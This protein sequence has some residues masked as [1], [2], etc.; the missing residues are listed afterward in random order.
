MQWWHWKRAEHAL[1]A[2]VRALIGAR[3]Y[4]IRF[5][6]GKGSFVNF[7]T[8]E[9]VI[10]PDMPDSLGGERLLPYTWRGR[11]VTTLAGLQWRCA[12][13]LARHEAAHVLFTQVSKSDRGGVHHWLINALEDGR[14]ERYLGAIAPWAWADFLELGL[15]VWQQY[16]LPSTRADR[17]LSAC[18]LHRWDVLRPKPSASRIALPHAA[19]RTLWEMQI[20]P[21]VECAWLVTDTDEVAAIASEIL[22]LLGIPETAS[23]P[24]SLSNP[25]GRGALGERAADDQP[26]SV[27]GAAIGSPTTADDGPV[28]EDSV[29]GADPPGIDV[30]LTSGHLLLHPYR[31]IEREVAGE[32]RRLISALAPPTPD[33]APRPHLVKGRFSAREHVRSNGEKPMLHHRECAPDP[34]GLALVLLIDRTGSMGNYQIAAGVPGEGFYNPSG[35][36]YHARRAALLLSLT[37][38]GARIPLCI[39]YAGN[40][41]APRHGPYAGRTLHLPQSVVWIRDWTTP[42]GA[43]GPLAALAGMYGDAGNAERISES[44]RLAQVKLRARR[45]R[46]RLIVYIHDGQP[47]DETPPTVAK[48]V[49]SVRRD[50]II[51]LGLFVG[52][53]RELPK[54]QAIFGA[55]DTIGVDELT[56]L[57][58]RLGAIL[59]R[60]YR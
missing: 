60:Y 46:T 52:D 22:T 47:T 17:L 35:R 28:G 2:W 33:T 7:S 10:E 25:I 3:P 4:T 48:T 24:A 36:M 19:D 13:A 57:P 55:N 56:K 5:A 34:R 29:E 18:L 40:E 44:L 41:V 16:A 45:E 58:E 27:A 6:T 1:D 53:Q 32:V 54:L 49:A 43:E 11:R 20:R 14:I 21:L 8:R 26:L 38:A 42:S 9:I 50:G 12:R 30:D 37:C 31:E 39:G 23:T 15:L 51:V 59:K